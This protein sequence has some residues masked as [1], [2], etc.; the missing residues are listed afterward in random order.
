MPAPIRHLA[1]LFAAVVMLSALLVIGQAAT[2][3][4]AI[5]TIPTVAKVSPS[6]GP[7]TG[8][9]AITITGT[10]FVT[11]ATVVI[12]Q[13]NGS[14]T[15]AIPVIDVHVASSTEITAVTGGGAKAGTWSLFVTTSGGTSAAN[16]GDDFTYTTSGII[17]TVSAVSPESGPTTGGTAITITGTGFATGASVKAETPA[18]PQNPAIA[19]TDVQV[20]SSTEITAVT[21]GGAFGGTYSLFVTTSGGLSAD[22]SGDHFTYTVAPPTVSKVSPNT[23]PTSGG[24]AITITG[25][26]F[27]PGYRGSVEVV[28]GQGQG[29]GNSAI[30]ATNVKVVSSTEI[31]A[32]TG[33]PALPGTFSLY[34]TTPN[35][36]STGNTGDDFTY[37]G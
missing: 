17:P 9:T 20:I 10:G 13:G 31:T 7:I 29:P 24:T 25:T 4:A 16:I 15:G 12:G 11:G 8:G 27:N 19:A 32:T 33:G 26:S 30:P 18:Q 36:T 37:T 5:N 23:G 21:G 34:V 35:G 6:T 2:A 22:N 1:H 28:I 14:G 3:S